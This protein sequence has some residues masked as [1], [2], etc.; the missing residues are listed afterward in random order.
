MLQQLFMVPQFRYQLL[1]AV[2]QTPEAIV[3]Y[4]G[5]MIDDNLLRQLQILFGYL[6]SSDRHAACP[7]ALCFAFK[8]YDGAPTATGE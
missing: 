1:K 2:E 8:D 7:K 6:E 3:E 5:D 4:K